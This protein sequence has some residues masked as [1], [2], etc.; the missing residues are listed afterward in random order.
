MLTQI[1]HQKVVKASVCALTAGCLWTPAALAAPVASDGEAV[2]EFA[3]PNTT[4]LAVRQQQLSLHQA[5]GLT[6]LGMMAVTLALG[7]GVSDGWLS[8]ALREPHIAAGGLSAGLYLA[9]TA[10]SLTA[11]P[12]PLAGAESPW[13]SVDWHRNLGWLHMAGMASTVGLGIGNIL[14]PGNLTEVHG[15]ASYF[16]LSLMA[17][18]A[19]IVAFGE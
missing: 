2:E 17:S 5:L 9:S 1:L 8:P 3:A 6:T 19:A 4:V 7:K 16:T 13:D 12:S 18:S 14:G 15:L 11:P 10:L